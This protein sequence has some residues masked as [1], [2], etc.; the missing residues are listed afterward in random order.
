M[1]HFEGHRIKSMRNI[2][3]SPEWFD[4]EKKE[5]REIVILI[6]FITT[7]ISFDIHNPL[8]NRIFGRTFSQSMSVVLVESV[9]LQCVIRN[10]CECL[11]FEPCRS[12]MKMKLLIIPERFE[13]MNMDN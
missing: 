3:T 9:G 12:K 8:P 11:Y 7:L 5:I 6:R 2:L 10:G 13:A 4:V 1:W